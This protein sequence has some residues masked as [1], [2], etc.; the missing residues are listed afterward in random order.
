V[1]RGIW[2]FQVSLYEGAEGCASSNKAALPHCF[3][4]QSGAS[5][6]VAPAMLRRDTRFLE[7]RNKGSLNW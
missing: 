1:C 6:S 5:R 7:A 3:I 2:T 4:T